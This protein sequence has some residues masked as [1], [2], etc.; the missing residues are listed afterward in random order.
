MSIIHMQIVFKLNQWNISSLI[1]KLHKLSLSSNSSALKILSQSKF[2][3]EKLMRWFISLLS[4]QALSRNKR[5]SFFVF[6]NDINQA[7]NSICWASTKPLLVY[8]AKSLVRSN[9]CV[10][11]DL[12]LTT[13]SQSHP[14]CCVTLWMIHLSI[15]AFR[16]VKNIIIIFRKETH[17][18]IRL[19]RNVQTSHY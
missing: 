3:T 19:Q 7:I 4:Q 12:C 11:Q 9:L 2:N 1:L 10:S 6:L 8:I 13:F 15:R 5:Q 14:L 17:R 18:R 16:H